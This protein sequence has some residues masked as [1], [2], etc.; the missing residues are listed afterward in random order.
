MRGELLP[1]LDGQ[2]MPLEIISLV[3]PRQLCDAYCIHATVQDCRAVRSLAD[4]QSDR[5][6]LL[7]LARGASGGLLP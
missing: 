2:A 6:I 5:E 1:R 7:T 3:W 4:A